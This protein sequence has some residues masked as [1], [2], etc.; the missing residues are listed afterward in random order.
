[1]TN[2]MKNILRQNAR[3]NVADLPALALSLYR[4]R[5]LRDWSQVWLS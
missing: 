1:M 3:F 5:G 2:K 4:E